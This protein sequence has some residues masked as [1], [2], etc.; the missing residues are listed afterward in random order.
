MNS[1]K[2]LLLLLFIVAI[3][4][5]SCQ[6]PKGTNISGV[7]ENANDMSYYFEKLGINN[8]STESLTSDKLDN[9]G[10]FKLNLPNGIDAGVYRLRVGAKSIE[11]VSNGSEKKIAVKANL[12]TMQDRDFTIEGSPMTSEYYNILNKAV[13]RTYDAGKLKELVTST[14]PMLAYMIASRI[15]SFRDDFADVHNTVAKRLEESYPNL[16]FLSD[17][18]NIALQLDQARNRKEATAKIQVGMQAPDIVL[19]NTKGKEVKLSDYKGKVVLIDFW[20]SWC[21]PCRKANPHVVEVYN[22]Y[23][24]KGFDIL[25]VSLDGLDDK[26]MARLNNDQAQ[27]KMNMDRQKERWLAAIQQD[28]LTWDG[29][30]SDLKKWDSQA[31]SLY[32]VTSIPK[33]FLIDREGKISAV[34]PRFNLEEAVKAAL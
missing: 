27:I 3:Q 2:L 7:I 28:N 24:S 19:P 1:S 8:N 17:Y 9:K 31:A 15:F 20:A 18:K 32:G 26:T 34:D 25:S 21:G 10:N 5:T 4:F 23:K 6:E 16:Y 13:D 12:N 22:K 14:D 30:V 33:T 11:L 29:H